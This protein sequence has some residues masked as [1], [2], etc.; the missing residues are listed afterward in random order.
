MTGI[1][2]QVMGDTSQEVQE[3][4]LFKSIKE[5]SVTANIIVCSGQLLVTSEQL[6]NCSLSG[7]LLNLQAH[8]KFLYSRVMAPDLGSYTCTRIVLWLEVFVS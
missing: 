4:S 8:E 5:A 3:F 2:S 6:L 7:I 1:E